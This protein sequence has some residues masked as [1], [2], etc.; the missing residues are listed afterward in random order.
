MADPKP[1]RWRNLRLPGVLSILVAIALGST[2]GIPMWFGRG[3]ITLNS[4][5]RLLVD[6]LTE[7]RERASYLH[8]DLQ[9]NF[10]EDGGGYIISDDKGF[11]LAAPLGPGRF[12]REYDIDAVFR[13]V[14]ISALEIEGSSERYVR[15]D[16]NGSF[17]AFSQVEMSFK[18]QRRTIIIDPKTGVIRLQPGPLRATT[19]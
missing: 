5:A 10:D 2:V 16:P 18:D 7:M 14:R 4:A 3:D 12:L 8:V 19:E 11:P 15:V 6:D 13:G 17:A 1:S 9:V